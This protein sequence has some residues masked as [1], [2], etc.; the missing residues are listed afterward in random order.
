MTPGAHVV[1]DSTLVSQ[2]VFYRDGKAVVIGTHNTQAPHGVRRQHFAQCGVQAQR[3]AVDL[4]QNHRKGEKLRDP[5]QSE[6]KSRVTGIP[7]WLAVGVNDK[8]SG[9]Y[10]VCGIGKP[11]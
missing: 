2:Q 4:S 5:C 1:D 3:A 9:G 8:R 7:Q 10:R 11:V 6:R